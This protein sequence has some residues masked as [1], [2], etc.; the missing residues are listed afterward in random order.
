MVEKTVNLGE[1]IIKMYAPFTNTKTKMK[2]VL[3]EGSR[4]EI[5]EKY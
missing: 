3:L 1:D 2:S 4:F 5:D